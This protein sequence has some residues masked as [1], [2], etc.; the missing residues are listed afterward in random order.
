MTKSTTDRRK[1]LAVGGA[2]LMVGLAGCAAFRD[3]Q[4]VPG[5]TEPPDEHRNDRHPV[6]PIG[7]PNGDDP[8]DLED[9]EDDE[10]EED[11]E[12]DDEN[13]ENGEDEEDDGESGEDE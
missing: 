3:G 7:F 1:F 8:E 4:D 12:E 11:E 2:A 10:E 5:D 13:G 9:D 6:D